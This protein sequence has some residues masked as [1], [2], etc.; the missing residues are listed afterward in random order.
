MEESREPK[1]LKGFLKRLKK[2]I[3]LYDKIGSNIETIE[4]SDKR[5]IRSRL[6]YRLVFV[7][8][9]NIPHYRLLKGDTI[10]EVSL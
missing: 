7:L 6:L 9:N 1:K 10:L 8:L 4:Y 3:N 2:E 5:K